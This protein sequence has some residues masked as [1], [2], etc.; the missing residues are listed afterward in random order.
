LLGV[1]F[2]HFVPATYQTNLFEDA[3]E[4]KNLYKAIDEV[5]DKFGKNSLVRAAGKRK[6]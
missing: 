6:K 5:K 1:R 4:M 3:D 2:S